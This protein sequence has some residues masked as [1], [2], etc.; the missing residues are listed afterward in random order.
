MSEI[1]KDIPGHE[2]LYQASDHG[3]IRS[4]DRTIKVRNRWGAI[5]ER[6]IKGVILRPCSN[7]KRGGYRQ[8]SLSPK[9][10]RRVAVLVAAAFLGPRP[11]GME[12]CHND[13]NS[14]NDAAKNL[15]YDT[16]KG[17][18]MDQIAH[19][20][21]GRGEKHSQARLTTSD[22]LFIRSDKFAPRQEL[23]KMFGVDVRHIDSIRSGRRWKYV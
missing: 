4:L 3:N 7:L 9:T 19:G 11:V 22:V 8:V 21:R 17:N 2:G 16:P 10:Q 12:V 18:A 20:T 5:T 14:T 6:T 15:R 13:G 1:W 23:A